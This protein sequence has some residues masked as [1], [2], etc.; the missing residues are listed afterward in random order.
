MKEDRGAPPLE[1]TAAPARNFSLA[2]DARVRAL[3]GPPPYAVRRRRI[4]D[5]EAELLREMADA[6]DADPCGARAALQAL[7]SV[8]ARLAH[9]NRLIAAHNVYYP[10][11][12]NLPMDPR[13]GVLV[14]RGEPWRPLPPLTF[15]ALFARAASREA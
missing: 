4:E 8:A 3:G 10:I 1:N 14:E 2:L 9:M 12:A 11:E 7:P 13:R 15:D 6:L 5:L